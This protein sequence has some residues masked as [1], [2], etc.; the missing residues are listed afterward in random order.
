VNADFNRE[1]FLEM[2]KETPGYPIALYD[3][4][5]TDQEMSDLM[6]ACDCYVSLHRSEGVGVTISDAMSA[7]KPV[8][9]TGWSGNMDFMTISTSFP[10]RY[11]LVKLERDIAQYRAGDIWA[12][13][14]IDQAAET[15]RYVF[16]HRDEATRRGEAARS[17]IQSDYSPEAVGEL[18]SR[19][20]AVIRS[21]KRFDA[22]KDCIRSDSGTGLLIDHFSE[23]GDY[24]P[25]NQ[26]RYQ[27]L[28]TD[29]QHLL[30]S[31]VPPGATLAIVSKGD[32]ELMNLAGRRT[33]HFPHDANYR[34]AGHHPKDSEEA[35]ELVEAVRAK[36]GEYLVFPSTAFWWFDHYAEFHEHLLTRYKIAHRDES[37]VMF[38]LRSACHDPS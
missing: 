17:A 12:E 31:R 2:Q 14:S 13:P 18:I 16:E 4:H 29:L 22:L 34:Y 5:W 25:T 11:N 32:D 9:A 37:C 19:R 21:K 7:G 3:G 15:M 35:I 8:I 1:H 24:A 38:E 36:G 30:Q 10:V 20:L 33:W 27:Q 6:A 28:K 26:L 23:L